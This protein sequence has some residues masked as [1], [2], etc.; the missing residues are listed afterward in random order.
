MTAR[1]SN[2]AAAKDPRKTW[3]GLQLWRNRRAHQLQVEPL[4]SICQAEGRITGATVADHNPPHKDDY[5]Q[6]VTGPLRSLCSP[7]HDALQ[8]FTHKPYRSDVGVDG[9]PLDPAHPFYRS[10]G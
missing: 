8:G 5:N 1:L 10:G 6:F 2:P 9:F 3:Y 4:C 7:C